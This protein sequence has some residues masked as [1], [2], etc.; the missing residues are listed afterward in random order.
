MAYRPVVESFYAPLQE[1]LGKAAEVPKDE[2]T[3][4]TT[5]IVCPDCGSPMVF[6]L[7][8]RGKFLG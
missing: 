2:I 7:G 8:R 1:R 3:T 4:E 5:D 6:K